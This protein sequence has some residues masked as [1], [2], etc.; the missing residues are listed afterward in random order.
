MLID[1]FSLLTDKVDEKKK[2]LSALMIKDLAKM[3]MK[4]MD[5]NNSK[6]LDWIEFKQYFKVA[7]GMEEKIA[8]YIKSFLVD[9]NGNKSKIN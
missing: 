9:Q 5:V 6:D 2:K 3:I 8:S 1:S 4:E 7:S